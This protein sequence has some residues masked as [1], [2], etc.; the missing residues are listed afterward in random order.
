M[1]PRPTPFAVDV[2]PDGGRTIVTP[3]GELDLATVDQLA[4]SLQ[5]AVD[6]G[7]GTIVLD[8]R[9][10]EFIDST[11]LSL[12]LQQT[13]RPD[14]TVQLVDGTAPVARL[15]DLTGIRDALPFVAPPEGT[16]RSDH[17]RDGGRN[18][19]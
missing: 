8:L 19:R 16:L 11:G 7:A 1:P 9:R 3:E 14:A 18:G 15:F 13:R 12:L 10:L 2:R 6:R 17:D 5:G 4:R